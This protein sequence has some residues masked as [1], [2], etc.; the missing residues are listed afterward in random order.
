MHRPTYG[1]YDSGDNYGHME[2]ILWVTLG[3]II[4]AE[5]LLTIWYVIKNAAQEHYNKIAMWDE[6]VLE[7]K[8]T[9]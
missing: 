7:N 9:L 5:N 1:N 4:I 6:F 8:L 2:R 3:L